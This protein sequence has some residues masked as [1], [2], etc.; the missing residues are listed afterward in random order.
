MNGSRRGVLR[1]FFALWPGDGL[2]GELAARAAAVGKACAGRATR[3]ESIHLTLVFVGAT[4]ADR[5]D[6]LRAMMD[7][8]RVPA[9]GFAFDRL[10]WFRHNRVVWAGVASPPEPLIDLQRAVARGAARLGFSLDVRPYVPHLTL[11]RD[12][13][14]APPATDVAPLDWNVSSFV[15]VASDLLPEG[16]R[17]RILHETPLQAER[18]STVEGSP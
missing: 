18:I 17:H 3:A 7:A 16:A 6:S 4:P 13:L 14:R 5:I 12:A 8:V 1:T 2:R 15:L 10:G 11:A 9:F